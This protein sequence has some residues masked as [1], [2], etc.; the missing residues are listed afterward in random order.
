M[1][2]VPKGQQSYASF[3]SIHTYIHT[4]I[5]TH[6]QEYVDPIRITYTYAGGTEGPTIIRWLREMDAEDGE[7]EESFVDLKVENPKS[8]QPTVDEYDR[9]LKLLITPVRCV[10]NVCMYVCDL[11][12]T[13]VYVCM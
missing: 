8:Y 9:R 5:H 2:A 10:L 6:V 13:Y 11:V 4:Y 7:E 3:A 1:L 12:C